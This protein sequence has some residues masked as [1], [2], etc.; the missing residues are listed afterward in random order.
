MLGY[1]VDALNHDPAS[2]PYLVHIL[3]DEGGELLGR[4]GCHAA[5]DEAGEVEIGYFV[6]ESAR[7][8]G[9][10]GRAVD[11]F[12]VWLQDNGVTKLRATARPDNDASIKI[13]RRRG[14]VEVGSQIDPED[15]LELVF[16]RPLS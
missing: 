14:F 7:G 1:R 12:L 16:Q 13:L 5:P 11:Q 3:L 8:R 10:A 4:I 2:A 15:G 6:R 9:I